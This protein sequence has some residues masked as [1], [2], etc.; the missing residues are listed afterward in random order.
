MHGYIEKWFKI[1]LTAKRD[2]LRYFLQLND[3]KTSRKL[4]ERISYTM[5]E[6]F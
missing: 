6:I 4:V 5:E 2:R 3:L 1:S